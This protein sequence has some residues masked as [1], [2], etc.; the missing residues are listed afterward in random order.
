MRR[1]RG[2]DSDRGLQRAPHTREEKSEEEGDE[3]TRRHHYASAG[4]SSNARL[5]G[6]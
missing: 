5:T 2:R 6:H 4:N 3:D 1:G